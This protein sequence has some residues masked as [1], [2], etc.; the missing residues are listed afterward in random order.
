VTTEE[1]EPPRPISVHTWYAGRAGVATVTTIDDD[2]VSAADGVTLVCNCCDPPQR[3]FIPVTFALYLAK[4]I[5][6]AA[7]AFQW[8]VEAGWEITDLPSDDLGMSDS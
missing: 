4:C 3:H 7:I 5:A 1:E 2:G 8:K 6:E